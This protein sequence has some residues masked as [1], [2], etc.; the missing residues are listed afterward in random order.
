LHLQLR[1]HV[2]ALNELDIHIVAVATPYSNEIN[3]KLEYFLA[4]QSFEVTSI[5][6]KLQI[7]TSLPTIQKS[8]EKTIKIK[9]FKRD[10]TRKDFHWVHPKEIY[11]IVL[12]KVDVFGATVCS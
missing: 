3:Q 10:A 5:R 11:E 2:E 8:I 1:A 12:N 4:H 7:K 9:H 6:T